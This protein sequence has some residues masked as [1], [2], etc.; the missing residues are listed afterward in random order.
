[1]I[2]TDLPCLVAVAV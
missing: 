2:W 1:M